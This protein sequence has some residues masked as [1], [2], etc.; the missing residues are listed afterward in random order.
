MAYFATSANAAYGLL[1]RIAAV[2]LRQRYILSHQVLQNTGK[3]EQH[4][5][6]NWFAQGRNGLLRHFEREKSR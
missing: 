5:I 4:V 2:A 1:H 6:T 3:K